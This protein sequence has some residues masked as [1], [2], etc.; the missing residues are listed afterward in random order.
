MTDK[1]AKID[2]LISREEETLKTAMANALEAMDKSATVANVRN[3]TAAKKALEDFQTK[4]AGEES[5]ERFRNLEQAAAWVIGQGYIVSPRS[6][7][8]HADRPGFPKR[9]KDGY[10][11]SEIKTYADG[12]WENP[13][14]PLVDPGASST[15][16]RDE[17]VAEQVRKLR[18]A[19]EITEGN[20]ILRSLVEQEFAARASFLKRDLFNLGPRFVDRMVEQLVTLLKEL[21]IPLEGVNFS[22]IIPDL[23]QYWDKKIAEHLNEYAKSRGFIPAPEQTVSVE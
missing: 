11:K 17:L 5:G 15:A 4:K 16:G 19:N 14:K 9:Q 12:A 6:V 1:T 23:E 7:R 10:L 13:N 3:Y 22:S 21:E 20:Y 8:N 2:D 18:L